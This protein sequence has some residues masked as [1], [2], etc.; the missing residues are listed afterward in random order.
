MGNTAANRIFPVKT[1]FDVRS[2]SEWNDSVYNNFHINTDTTIPTINFQCPSYKESSTR[3]WDW[4]LRQITIQIMSAPSDSPFAYFVWGISKTSFARA[5]LA[6]DLDS[7]QTDESGILGGDSGIR[8]SKV[9]D[10]NYAFCGIRCAFDIATGGV[11]ALQ[12]ADRHIFKELEQDINKYYWQN[13]LLPLLDKTGTHQSNT[14]LHELVSQW[15]EMK[16]NGQN[17]FISK[18]AD[19]LWNRDI[20]LIQVLIPNG[21]FLTHVG[22]GSSVPNSKTVRSARDAAIIQAYS[23]QRIFQGPNGLWVIDYP[24]TL[25]LMGPPLLVQGFEFKRALNHCMNGLDSKNRA[26]ILDKDQNS[27]MCVRAF[28]DNEG[29]GRINNQDNINLPTY[30]DWLI[31][32]YAEKY[33]Y[34]PPECWCLRPDLAPQSRIDIPIGIE[35][36]MHNQMANTGFGT[37]ND[38]QS[39]CFSPTCVVQKF[40]DDRDYLLTTDLID[41]LCTNATGVKVCSVSEFVVNSP[42]YESNLRD[43]VSQYCGSTVAPTYLAEDEKS[44]HSKTVASIKKWIESTMGMEII[45]LVLGVLLLLWA[46]YGFGFSQHDEQ[47]TKVHRLLNEEEEEEEEEE[48]EEDG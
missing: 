46:F 5:G 2:T 19:N 44:N 22:F 26:A 47:V 31:R 34:M 9:R 25:P 24:K 13:Q 43:K 33:N 16:R 12:F 38:K 30:Y 40:T 48:W 4:F 45:I 17:I 36:F 1:Q 14:L 27:T 21:G 3:D 18:A 28:Y 11:F 20:G 39:T 41:P 35:Y 37:N 7:M 15:D 6:M 23:P 32:S 42:N 8:F 29:H 10:Q